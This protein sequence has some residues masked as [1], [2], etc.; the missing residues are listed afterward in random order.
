LAGAVARPE[1]ALLEHPRRRRRSCTSLRCV[2]SRRR[3]PI[4]PRP[5]AAPGRLPGSPQP[6]PDH[7]SR[8]AWCRA[9]GRRD[10]LPRRTGDYLPSYDLSGSVGLRL[11]SLRSLRPGPQGRALAGTARL[12]FVYS[13]ARSPTKLVPLKRLHGRRR[14]APARAGLRCAPP[15]VAADGAPGTPAPET[16]LTL[17]VAGS[18]LPYAS[19][20]DASEPPARLG[21][22]SCA[23]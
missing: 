6:P 13:A 3:P 11:R 12:G 18:S 20:A 4:Q 5:S 7:G 21:S 14:F 22:P 19:A 15:T 9:A 2:A 8:C 16:P 10:P 23:A 17:R 1:A